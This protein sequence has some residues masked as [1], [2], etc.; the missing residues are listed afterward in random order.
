M[1]NL[2]SHA[3]V[4]GAFLEWSITPSFTIPGQPY[5]TKLVSASSQNDGY[6]DP[7]VLNMISFDF[8]ARTLLTNG[9]VVSLVSVLS[10]TNVPANLNGTRFNC[11]DIGTS[12]AETN[13][14]MVIV[15]VIRP[16]D[17]GEFNRQLIFSIV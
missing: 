1:E 9:S 12:L 8:S 11:T 16:A 14:T 10:V 13:T 6:V 17:V 4:T 7:L 2:P 5:R 3:V 15:H